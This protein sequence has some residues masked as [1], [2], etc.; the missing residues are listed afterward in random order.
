MSSSNSNNIKKT[1]NPNNVEVHRGRL[2][3]LSDFYV[4]DMKKDL[5]TPLLVGRGFLAT[6]NAAI[7][8][9]KAKIM[10]GEGITR[11]EF[12]DC[13]LPGEWEIARDAEI[14]PFEDVL[15]LWRL[16]H[17]SWDTPPSVHALAAMKL[18]PSS[19]SYIPISQS[20]YLY[21]TPI[22]HLLH[23]M[24]FLYAQ[25][26]NLGNKLE[27]SLTTQL[28]STLDEILPRLIADSLEETLHDMLSNPL[29]QKFHQLLNDSIK[30]NLLG[31]NKKFKQ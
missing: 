1:F 27:S 15:E 29:S 3:L 5:E 26:Y 21:Q 7:D 16:K 31:L 24:D 13:H 30:E 23:R 28:W 19:S 4:I 17:I 8:C 18:L 9:R 12:L 10:V 25:V 14:N 20:I 11:K 22:G 2:K 6:A